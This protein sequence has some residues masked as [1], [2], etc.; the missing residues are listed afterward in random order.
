MF[1][2]IGSAPFFAH[3]L[4]DDDDHLRPSAYDLYEAKEPELVER[5]WQAQISL[6]EVPAHREDLEGIQESDEAIMAMARTFPP[7]AAAMRAA[8]TCEE[9]PALIAALKE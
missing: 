5:I 2:R 1:E 8:T 6:D 3:N 4:G 9:I 7:V